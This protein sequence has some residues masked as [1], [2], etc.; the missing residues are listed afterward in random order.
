M[1]ESWT[2][3]VECRSDAFHWYGGCADGMARGETIRKLYGMHCNSGEVDNAMRLKA[4]VV[5]P[6]I[7]SLRD[8]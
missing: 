6:S 3:V 5:R 2:L 7:A 4:K 1:E 8:L